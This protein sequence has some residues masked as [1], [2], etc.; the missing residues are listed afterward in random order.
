MNS[1]RFDLL[2]E[3]NNIGSGGALTSLSKLVNN[4]IQIHVP[5]IR[6]IEFDKV[7][8]ELDYKNEDKLLGVLVQIEG[9]LNATLMFMLT[10]NAAN[11]FVSTLLGTPKKDDDT[12]D[13]M[14][15][16][17]IKEIG[18]IMFNAYV[19]T[20]TSMTQKKLKLSIPYTSI[21]MP[22]AILSVPA[23]MYGQISDKG[24][25]VESIFDID[26]EEFYAHLV[27]VPDKESYDILAVSMGVE[28]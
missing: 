26:G 9:E 5:N 25:F 16:S 10:I 11:A 15:L 13:E 28:S 19:N 17:V 20:L 2:K 18:N 23:I 21:D 24:V 8:K 4:H 1:M 22:Q 27:M 6:T 7:A 3:L 12:F 14:Q